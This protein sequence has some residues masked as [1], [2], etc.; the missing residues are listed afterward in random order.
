MSTGEG[1]PGGLVLAAALLLPLGEDSSRLPRP[2]EPDRSLSYSRSL[3]AGDGAQTADQ[4]EAV[5]LVRNW[6][7]P[8]S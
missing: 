3:A 7:S 4:K 2:R 8:P 5:A 6:R 1:Y